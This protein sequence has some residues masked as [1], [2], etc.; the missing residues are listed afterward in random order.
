MFSELEQ[1]YFEKMLNAQFREVHNK[2]DHIYTEVSK[3]NVRVDKLEQ[4]V[5]VLSKWKASS[6]GNWLGITRT[7]IVIWVILAFIGGIV[8][9]YLWH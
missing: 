6:Q 8:A 4:E 5:D 7:I 2:L 3:I 1:D 9:T